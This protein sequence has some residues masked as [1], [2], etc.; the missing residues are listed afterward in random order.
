MADL[1]NDV[2]RE[3]QRMLQSISTKA[4]ELRAMEA[5][6]ERY[7]KIAGILGNGRGGSRPVRRASRGKRR[8]DWNVILGRLDKSFSSG[9][10]RKTAGTGPKQ[11]DVHQALLRWVK[12]GRVKRISKGQYRKA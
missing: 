8:T 2:Q 11:A 1:R 4:A 9:D 12:D 10:V 3:I 6:L 5:D 7:K